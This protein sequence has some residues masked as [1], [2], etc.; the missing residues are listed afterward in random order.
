MPLCQLQACLRQAAGS[1]GI[2]SLLA[3]RMKDFM[4]IPRDEAGAL[5]MLKAAGGWVCHSH[6]VSR[7]QQIQCRVMSDFLVHSPPSSHCVLTWWDG[8]RG[9]QGVTQMV[10]QGSDIYKN[11]DG[12]PLSIRWSSP[13]QHTCCSTNSPHPC[14]FQSLA[15]FLKAWKQPVSAEEVLKPAKRKCSPSSISPAQ[16]NRP[17]LSASPS[18]PFLSPTAFGG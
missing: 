4:D 12:V 10:P 17:L 16:G 9:R 5:L 11:Q 3:P 14:F 18:G 1:W 8:E 7:H 15:T 6:D 13:R 2:I